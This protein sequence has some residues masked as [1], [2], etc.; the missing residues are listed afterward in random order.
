MLAIY[1]SEIA[2]PTANCRRQ[3]FALSCGTGS[4]YD[5]LHKR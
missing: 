5:P 4:A 1:L 3:H 2:L